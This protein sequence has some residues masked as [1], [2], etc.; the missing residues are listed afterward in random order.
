MRDGGRQY[1]DLA[2]GQFLRALW[3]V[4]IDEFSAGVMGAARTR[5]CTWV[6]WG[7]LVRAA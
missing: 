4:V 6:A 2:C 3:P 5:R 7:R 1:A